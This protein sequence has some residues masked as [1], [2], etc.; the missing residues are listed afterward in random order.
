MHG[1]GSLSCPCCATLEIVT[2]LREAIQRGVVW[3]RL[4][5]QPEAGL[6]FKFLPT[7]KSV[8]T[9]GLRVKLDVWDFCGYVGMCE[10]EETRSP[11]KRRDDPGSG[12]CR[13]KRLAYASR[14][15]SR[16]GAIR[17]AAIHRVAR[18]K[19]GARTRAKTPVLARTF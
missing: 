4:W 7:F 13:T 14:A 18:S 8:A 5:L 1:V 12:N 17:M 15:A 3:P 2:A 19:T 9:N 6:T 11:E 10:Q 16:T